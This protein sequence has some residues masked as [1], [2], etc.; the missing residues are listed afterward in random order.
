MDHTSR[1][2]IW[3]YGNIT[4]AVDCADRFP[5]RPELCVP[6]RPGAPAYMSWRW[7]HGQQPFREVVTDITIHNDPGNWAA[8]NGYYLILLNPK[9]SGTTFYFGL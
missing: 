8:R 3:R 9:I 6:T 7:D 1:S 2:G 4:L 5:D